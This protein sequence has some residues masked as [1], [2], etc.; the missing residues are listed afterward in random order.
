MSRKKRTLE[1]TYKVFCEG[2]SEY[3]YVEG[4]R[5][6]KKYSIA[7]KPVNMAG[8][9][10]SNFIKELKKD[11]NSNCLVKFIIIDSDKA[12]E[13]VEEQKKLCELIAFCRLQNDCKR[14]PHILV[15]NAPDF[16]YIACLHDLR[17]DR[18]KS[19]KLFIEKQMAYKDIDAFKA[20]KKI[21]QVLNSKNNSIEHMLSRLDNFT[22]VI[23]HRWNLNKSTYDVKI[24][25]TEVNMNNIYR[26]GSNINEL[27]EI[28]EN[29]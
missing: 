17:Y 14:I 11:A 7:I 13:R 6:A 5:Q 15:I 18:N 21:Y 1:K 29:L 23:C 10:Y 8:G 3:N 19:T 4:L 27:F 24:K 12:L 22:A 9:G 2:D 16:E 28:L 25:D 26:K 20:D